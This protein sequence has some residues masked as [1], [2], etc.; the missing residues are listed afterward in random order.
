MHQVTAAVLHS[1]LK[2]AFEKDEPNEH[3]IDNWL[4]EVTTKSP[5]AMFWLEVLNLEILLLSFV[6]AV[7]EGNFSLYKECLKKMMPWFFAFDHSNYARWVAVHLKDM[8]E[9][10]QKVP[11]VYE[12]FQ[13]NG[14]VSFGKCA[15]L[16]QTIGYTYLTLCIF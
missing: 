13:N 3:S 5:T 8:E 12:E 11:S 1:L 6:R 14:K 10:A 4:Q 2:E 16:Y 7:R 15:Q 9:L